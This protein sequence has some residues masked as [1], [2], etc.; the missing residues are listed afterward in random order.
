METVYR[1][2]VQRV[3]LKYMVR[4]MDVGETVPA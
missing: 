2:H 4:K 1:L 3:V